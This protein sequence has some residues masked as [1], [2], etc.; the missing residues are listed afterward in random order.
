MD[1]LMIVYFFILG[2]VF[3]S[4]FNVIG[5]RVPVNQSI[6]F[7]R[8]HCPSC[9]HQLRWFELIPLLSF[10]LLNGK[11]KQC[12]SKLSV[13]YPITEILTGALFAYSYMK[14]GWDIDLLFVLLFISLMI[15]ITVTDIIYM[16][17][18]DRILLF[19]CSVFIFLRI[20]YPTNPWWD[21][22]VGAI[23]G[24]SLLL[25][26]AIISKGAMGGGDV[27]LFFVIGLI[28]GTKLSLL[29]FIL[30]TILGAIYGIFIIIV[31]KYKKRK[32]IPF[33]PFI[34]LASIISLFYGNVIISWYF[35]VLL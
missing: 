4:F 35:G 1:S 19:F 16:L 18:P 5:L 8:S 9:K 20:F 32:P 11:C 15:I 10:L 28:L 23:I 25:F 21:F 27:K 14:I 3:G 7:P 13:L 31:G 26:I 24:F 33:G 22:I 12:K 2:L 29:T 30:A 17:I 34:S 6:F